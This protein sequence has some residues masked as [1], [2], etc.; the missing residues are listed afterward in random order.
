[1]TIAVISVAVMAITLFVL[2]FLVSV[3]RGQTDT[4]AYADGNDPTATLTKA[5]RG[6]GN[7][8][9]WVPI[10]SIL[11]LYLGTTDPAM[12]LQILFAVIALARVLT[13]IGFLTCETLTKLHPLKAL[14]AMVT[15]IGG[16]ILAVMA[17]LSVI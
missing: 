5:V 14:G 17:V 11:I 8:A 2:G 10:L 9:E 4:I 15:Y 6:H 13:V 1:M 12:W 3:L 7:S 16:T